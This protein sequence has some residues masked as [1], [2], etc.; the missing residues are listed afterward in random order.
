LLTSIFTDRGIAIVTGYVLFLGFSSL[1]LF[2]LVVNSFS[3]TATGTQQPVQQPNF[4]QTQPQQNTQWP[5]RDNQEPTFWEQQQQ[6]RE[7]RR[8]RRQECI[9]VEQNRGLDLFE[10]QR[11]CGSTWY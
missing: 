11:I 5:Q 9:R 7:E 1:I 2:G 3:Q 10:A 8:K 6:E 4:Q